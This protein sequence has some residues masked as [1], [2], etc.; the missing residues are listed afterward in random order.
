MNPRD[1]TGLTLMELLVALAL[2]AVIAGALASSTRFGVQL[3]SRTSAL[4]KNDPAIAMRLRLRQWLRSAVSPSRITTFPASFSGD[5]TE[6]TFT[7][8][9]PA[10][11]AKNSAALRITLVSE[12][13]E[14]RLRVMEMDDTGNSLQQHDRLLADNVQDAQIRYF[15]A[16]TGEWYTK[17]PNPEQ[18]PMLVMVTV[19]PSSEPDWPDF[20]VKLEMSP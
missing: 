8:L 7:T 6:M 18:L 14:L 1:K 11:F 12:L 2:V 15:D 9:A 10:P 16:Q 13:Q 17:W 5:A 4:Q 19:A 20:V 3:L